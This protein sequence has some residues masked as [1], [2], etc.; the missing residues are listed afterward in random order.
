MTVLGFFRRFRQRNG[1][2]T[3][4]PGPVPEKILLGEY[5]ILI[6]EY[7]T[8]VGLRAASFHISVRR[9]GE[10]SDQVRLYS[11]FVNFIE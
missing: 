6:A 9:T 3:E 1:A 8:Q 5:S 4:I 7:L 10:L 11:A 2:V